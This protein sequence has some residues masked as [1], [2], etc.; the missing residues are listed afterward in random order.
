VVLEKRI[1]IASQGFF[2]VSD[3]P[4]DG[5]SLLRISHV[6]N[7][8]AESHQNIG[9]ARVDLLSEKTSVDPNLANDPRPYEMVREGLST[10]HDFIAG[11]R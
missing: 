1:A 3:D 4:L 10:T 9:I 11:G 2:L 8:R 7:P 5:C 6:E